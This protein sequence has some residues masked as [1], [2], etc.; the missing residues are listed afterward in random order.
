MAKVNLTSGRITAFECPKGKSQSFLWD[1]EVRGLAVRA[2][3]KSARK[4]YIFESSIKGRS[5]RITIGEIKTWTIPAARAEARRLQTIIDT[6]I[7]PRQQKKEAQA[8]KLAEGT[9]RKLK[10]QREVVTVGSAWSE[11]VAA[12]K[13]FW[14]ESHYSDHIKMVHAGGEIR[15]RSTKLT[16]AGP[17]AS[18]TGL[19]LVE[20][21]PDAVISWAKV[22]VLT[23]ATQARLALRL[24][25]AFINWCSEHSTYKDMIV[26]NAAQNKSAREI[27]GKPQTKDDALQKEQL[28]AWFSA[29]QKINNLV[30][31]SYLQ[32]IL[33]TGAR[34][35]EVSTILW[36]DVDFQW[37]SLT[38]RDKV[39]GTRTIP[40]TPFVKQLMANLPR[41]NQFVFS[42]PT[43]ASGYIINAHKENGKACAITGLDITLHGYRRSFAS[44]SEWVEM[45]AGIAAQIQGHKP[46]GIREKNYIRRP[47]DLLRMWHVKIEEWILNE[48]GIE[49]SEATEVGLRAV[50]NAS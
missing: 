20:L 32:T 21:T 29:V 40:L 34:P 13:P 37:D 23:R 5:L 44:L 47:L 46:S 8:A 31:S 16:V 36:T 45:P 35:T 27:L 3:P 48:A 7:D 43:S 12:R 33:L 41:R 17:L 42:S 49:I 38:I 30:I 25:R 15:S 6:G 14:S 4:V 39:D 1:A 19:R 22:E 26:G 24:L 9:A 18:L 28:S 2:T 50:A 11:Y 10:A